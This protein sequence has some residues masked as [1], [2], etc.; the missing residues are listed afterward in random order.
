MTDMWPYTEV[1]SLA[2]SIQ[3]TNIQHQMIFWTARLLAWIAASKGKEPSQK[4]TW[5][6]HVPWEWSVGITPWDIPHAHPV[7]WITLLALCFFTQYLISPCGLWVSKTSF[8]SQELKL[9]A[10]LTW[11]QAIVSFHTSSGDWMSCFT[12]TTILPPGHYILHDT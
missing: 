6:L 12:P 9:P 1:K 7:L 11:L 10:S 8:W 4:I 2:Y 3:C 5:D